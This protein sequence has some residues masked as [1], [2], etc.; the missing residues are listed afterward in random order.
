MFHY[1]HKLE[2]TLC[3][4]N[5]NLV[6]NNNNQNQNIP[7]IVD[8]YGKLL[9]DYPGENQQ[10]RQNPTPHHQEY[11]RGY[12]NIADSDG[13]LVLPPLTQGKTFVVP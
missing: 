3:N 6:I 4:T 2:R 7:S 8:V 5:W 11:Y 10:K 12:D 13:T 1:D 9:L